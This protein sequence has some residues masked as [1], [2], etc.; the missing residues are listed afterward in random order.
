MKELEQNLPCYPCAL[1]VINQQ[2]WCCCHWA[3]VVIYD[4][5]LEARHRIPRLGWV[6]DVAQIDDQHVVI[7]TGNGLY[8]ASI[9]NVTGSYTSIDVGTCSSV[10]CHDEKVYSAFNDNEIRVYSTDTSGRSAWIKQRSFTVACGYLTLSVSNDSLLCCTSTSDNIAVYTLSG[11]FVEQRSLSRSPTRQG[12]NQLK[13]CYICDHDADGNILIGTW[14]SHEL[15]VIN[16]HGAVNSL[17]LEPRV[18][19]PQS[20]VV[21]KYHLYVTSWFNDTIA[22]YAW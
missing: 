18:L 13:T 17:Q 5:D 10:V 9:Q 8:H 15:Q 4:G 1:R 3:G 2:L 16:Q 6:F 14:G 21:F 12:S 7:A 19:Q 20:A 11:K 22:K